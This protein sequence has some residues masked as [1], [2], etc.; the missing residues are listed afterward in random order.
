MADGAGAATLTRD[1]AIALEAPEVRV[2]ATLK[3]TGRARY[4]G[5][6]YLPGSL[7]AKFLMS[8][9]PHARIV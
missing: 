6:V 5:D 4:T 2:D 8:P 3:T 7:W 1:V 9:Y